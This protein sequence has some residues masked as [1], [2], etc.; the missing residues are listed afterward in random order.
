MCTHGVCWSML[1]AHMVYAGA[2]Y[3]H[4]WCMLEH[5]MCTHGVCWSMSCAHM[6]YA[7]ACYVHAWCMLEHATCMRGYL[8]N[9]ITSHSRFSNWRHHPFPLVGFCVVFVHLV[10]H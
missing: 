5:A 2:C 6:V 3:V 7:G 1:C 10:G 8:H 9:V 4:A